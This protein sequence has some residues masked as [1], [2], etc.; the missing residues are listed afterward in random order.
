M[1]PPVHT[2]MAFSIGVA[3]A[4]IWYGMGASPCIWKVNTDWKGQATLPACSSPCTL[5]KSV[6]SDDAAALAPL[7]CMYSAP[8]ALTKMPLGT[9]TLAT[10]STMGASR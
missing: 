5:M 4:C 3:V 8:E 7:S 2:T 1:A 10:S 6:V 9:A